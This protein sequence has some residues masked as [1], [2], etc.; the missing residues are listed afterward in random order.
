MTMIPIL[1]LA[2]IVLLVGDVTTT[3]YALGI[4]A[5]E[6]NPIMA[7]IVH[8]PAIHLQ[9]KIAAAGI[10]LLLAN[11]AD[12]FRAGCGVYPLV[13]ACLFYTLPLINNLLWIRA[14]TGA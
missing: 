13:A 2:L 8:D 6:A 5:Q 14:A 11:Q 3:T 12:R 10:I 1:F 9:I 7:A 4:G